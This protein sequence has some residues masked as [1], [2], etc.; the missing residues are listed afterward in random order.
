MKKIRIFLALLPFMSLIINSC[1]SGLTYAEQLDEQKKAIQG[2]IRDSGIQVVKTIPTEV[3]W[4]DKVYYLTETGLYI[5]VIDTGLV[6]KTSIPENTQIMVRYRET[7]LDG[8]ENYNN[9]N[10]SV[11]PVTLYYGNV[12]TKSSDEDC[13]AWHEA[14]DYVGDKG[15]VTMIVPAAIGWAIYTTTSSLT[16]MFY[17]V[18]YTFYK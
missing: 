12:S 7:Y 3:P 1:D 15:H 11:D 10:S 13:D 5:H 16:P 17:E 6:V 18:H 9:M 8:E 2:Y 14:L 4:P